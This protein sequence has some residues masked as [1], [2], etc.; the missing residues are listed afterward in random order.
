ML[1]KDGQRLYLVSE[2]P[3]MQKRMVELEKEF[4]VSSKVE[5][6]PLEPPDIHT[7]KA[8]SQNVDSVIAEIRNAY[9]PYDMSSIMKMYNQL[10][11]EADNVLKN[12]KTK[13]LKAQILN[14]LNFIDGSDL[15]AR[16]RI[17]EMYK[18][19]RLFIKPFCIQL[20]THMGYAKF[21]DILSDDSVNFQDVYNKLMPALKK[22]V[23][24]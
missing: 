13:E 8:N 21:V 2:D 22:R 19:I 11:Y 7:S 4:N 12:F 5:T 10:P 18:Q 20:R 16:A 24:S 6:M 17:N 1:I 23:S 14:Y 15:D 9:N 3:A